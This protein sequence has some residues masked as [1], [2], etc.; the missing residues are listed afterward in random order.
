MLSGSLWE[1]AVWINFFER[2]N[3]NWSNVEHFCEKFNTILKFDERSFE[4]L[5]EEFLDYKSL[6]DKDLPASALEEAFLPEKSTSEHQEYRMDI[7]WYHLRQLK[8]PVA[9]N[10]RFKFLFDV[11]RLVVS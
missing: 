9:A 11:A 5:Y 4:S 7:I 3:A 1:H 8:N 2:S 10:M 6:R